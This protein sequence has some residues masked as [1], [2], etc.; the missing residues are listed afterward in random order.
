M[1]CTDILVF[2]GSG[3]YNV[4]A[5]R[6]QGILEVSKSTGVQFAGI[7]RKKL[8]DQADVAGKALAIDLDSGAAIDDTRA[9][10]L[11]EPRSQR[12]IV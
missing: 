1:N 12:V 8:E 6:P 9:L 7:V 11:F 2:G 5:K 4:A 3:N 10:L